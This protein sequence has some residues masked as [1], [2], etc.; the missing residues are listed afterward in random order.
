LTNDTEAFSIAKTGG[1]VPNIALLPP[2]R[3]Q[4]L[5]GAR[6]VF[7]ELGFERASVDLI[8]SR[9]GVSKATIYSHYQNKA[10][11]F[12]DCITHEAEEMR[13]AFC[14]CMAEPAGDVEPTLRLMGENI[15]RLFLSKS[16]VC[17]YRHI[18][19][20]AA[21]V[22]DVGQMIFDRGLRVIHETIASHLERWNRIG[23]L[24]ID[25][26]RAAAVQFVA[27]CQA[28][29]VARAR[30]A[31]LKDPLDEEVPETVRRAVWTFMRAYR[32]E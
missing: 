10:A 31:I 32:P 29:L 13:A 23:A 28:D 21:R 7:A 16:M 5:A 11:L 15:L 1:V 9:A 12:V 3:R 19:A 14:A 24:R 18:L 25:D 22:P 6:E 20:E 4:V 8:A 27:L 2:K 17:L 26:A 30:L